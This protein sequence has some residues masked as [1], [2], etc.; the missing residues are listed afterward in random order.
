MCKREDVKDVDV[1]EALLQWCGVNMVME[2]LRSLPLGTNYK[3]HI[4]HKRS[5]TDAGR[6]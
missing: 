3:A 4:V 6:G 2:R 5:V 1:N